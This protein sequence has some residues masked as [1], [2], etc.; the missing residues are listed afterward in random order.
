MASYLLQ[1]AYTPAAWSAMINK[2]QDRSKAIAG[3]VRKLGGKVEKFWMSFGEYDGVAIVDMPDSVSAAAFAMA[4]AGGGACK[5]V[6]TTPL[7]GLTEAMDAMAKAAT[8]GY[9]PATAE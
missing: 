7:I 3:A 9:Q 2:P 8:C 4:I 6:K 1:V 5:S